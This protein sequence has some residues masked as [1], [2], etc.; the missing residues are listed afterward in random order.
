MVVIRKDTRPCGAR[1]PKP[2]PELCADCAV[3]EEQSRRALERYRARQA[4]PPRRALPGRPD[5][6]HLRPPTGETLPCLTC[7]SKT[8]EAHGCALKGRCTKSLLVAGVEC[9]RLCPDYAAAAPPRDLAYYVAPVSGNGVW[10]RNCAKLLRHWHLFTGRKVIAVATG[11][12]VLRDDDRGVKRPCGLDPPDAV[13]AMF[14]GG[15][16]EILEIENDP[17]LREAK[18]LVPVFERLESREP[19]RVLFFGHAKGVTRPVNAGVTV[20]PWADILYDSLLGHWPAVEEV[21]SRHP[22]A[23]S[24]KKVGHGFQGSASAWHYSGSFCWLRSA[25]LFG[26]DWRRVDRRWWGS[27]SYPGLHF[28]VAEAGVV[29]HE[30]RVP[31]LDLYSMDYLRGTVYPAWERWLHENAHRRTQ[32]APA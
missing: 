14:A 1:H 7:T 17:A 18:A 29:F 19:G 10:Q 21:L 4:Q 11:G 26:R 24:F 22:L 23:G 2:V 16:A 30:G 12:S 6:R 25:D 27:E 3:F 31:S 32:G 8:A 9:C 13:R 20:H 28:S 5:C 15:G